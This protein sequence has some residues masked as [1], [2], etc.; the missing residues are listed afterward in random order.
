V[1]RPIGRFRPDPAEVLGWLTVA[2][3]VV[4]ILVATYDWRLPNR[5]GTSFGPVWAGLS[6]VGVALARLLRGRW[7]PVV[8]LAV[9]TAVA[10]L[11]TDLVQFNGQLL[12]DLGIY[13][14]AGEHFVAGAPVYLATIL[15]EAPV[16]KTT[17]PFLYPPPTLPVLAGRVGRR[18]DRRVAAARAVQPLGARDV[19]LAA[20][21]PGPV[22]G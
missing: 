4:Y 5:Y 20:V 9:G 2:I 8:L 7:E 18:C 13:L 3:L 19:A 12:R 14:R 17:Y 1:I 6:L 16:D 15:T 10:S 21:L 22:R 11:L